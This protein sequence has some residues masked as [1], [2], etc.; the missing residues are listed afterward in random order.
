MPD[1][2]SLTRVRDRLPPEV[3]TAVVQWVLRLVAEKGLLRGARY[4]SLPKTTSLGLKHPM[5]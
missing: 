2:S 4:V 1:H 5:T 3:H